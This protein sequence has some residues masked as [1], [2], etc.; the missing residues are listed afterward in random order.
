MGK[1]LPPSEKKS[2]AHQSEPG[3]SIRVHLPF[4]FSEIGDSNPEKSG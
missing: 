1:T 4:H 3:V 2:P